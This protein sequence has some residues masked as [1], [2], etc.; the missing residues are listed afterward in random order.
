[1]EIHSVAL[2]DYKHPIDGFANR[3]QT[4]GFGSGMHAS[5]LVGKTVA[6]L[7]KKGLRVPILSLAYLNAIAREEG[8][9][10]N[11]YTDMPKGE[12]IVIIASSML[13]HHHE[14][15]LANK[16]KKRFPNSR[17][18]FI[19]P[20]S[21]EYP[22]RFDTAS[23]FVIQD[24]P[25][26]VFRLICRGDLEPAGVIRPTD[27]VDLNSLPFPDW[28]GFDIGSY[29]YVPALPRKPFLTIQGSRGCPFACEF[30]PY[31]VMQGIP[32]RRRNNDHIIAEMRY[33]VDNYKI[34]SL[35]FRDITWSMNKKFSKDLCELIISQ[36]FDL[37]IGV[38]TRADTLDN[39][40][41]D[42]MARAGVKVVNL[43][44]ESPDEDILTA[45]GRRPIKDEK[46]RNIIQKLE[47]S[48][49]Q[50][51]GFYILGLIDDTEESIQKTINYSHKLNTYTAQFCVLTPI[52][53]TKTFRDLEHRLLTTDFSR[54][55]HYEPVVK[56]DGISSD[57]I[58][59]Y[60]NKAYN[61]YYLRPAWL[62]KHGF[63][64]AKS[65]LGM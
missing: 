4:G 56:I 47:Q 57:R 63:K 25:E 26:E 60:V 14:I 30:C 42:L 28:N 17:L 44:I 48:G 12:S 7:K 50:V 5:G 46:F 10:S 1:M 3:D 11:F 61:G 38:E 65:F 22:E 24:E 32:L 31:L 62:L 59:E 39:E 6:R 20:F 52:P 55:T 49:I 2:I 13:H 8:L 43:G 64:A 35:L 18:G 51:Q 41:V 23:D 9:E 40:L 19:G 29:G 58:S 33:L 16:I 15:D 53:G 54:F 36:E 21:G 37:D 27:K 45:S 34:K